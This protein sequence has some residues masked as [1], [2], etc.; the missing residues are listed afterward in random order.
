MADRG[1]PESRRSLPPE[2]LADLERLEASYLEASDPI[3][4]SGFGG[5]SERWRRERSP[6]LEAVTEDGDFLDVGCANGYLLECLIRWAAERGVRLS[7][8]GVDLGSR[9]IALARER[10]PAH[11]ETFWAANAWDFTP[12]RRFRYVYSLEDCVPA[13]HLREY[14]DRLLDRFVEPGGTLILGSYGSRSA[15]RPPRD[16]VT[17]LRA[18]GHDVEGSAT[19]GD[20]PVSSFAWIARSA[21]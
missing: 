1:P 6:I 12:P 5:G 15:G 3:R 10:H 8:S 21:G 9:L 13:S 17:T 18:W 7:P 4:Q 14:V 19:G 2:F 11:A 20:P 16:L